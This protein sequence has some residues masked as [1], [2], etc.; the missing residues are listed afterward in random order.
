MLNL[1]YYLSML[2][3]YIRVQLVVGLHYMASVGC[4][5]DII[6]SGSQMLY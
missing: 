2:C 1:F 5:Y 4:L 6:H 3:T